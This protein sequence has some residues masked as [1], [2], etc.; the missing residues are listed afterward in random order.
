MPLSAR[1]FDMQRLRS[2]RIAS[3]ASEAQWY[4]DPQPTERFA[5]I[6]AGQHDYDLM[7]EEHRRGVTD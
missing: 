3:E 4:Q 5:A 6:E 2:R 1:Q 7:H